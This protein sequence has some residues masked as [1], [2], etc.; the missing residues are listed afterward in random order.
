MEK[1]DILKLIEDVTA[2]AA[3]ASPEVR[4]KLQGKLLDLKSLLESKK[5]TGNPDYLDEK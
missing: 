1:A 3:G 5:D 2:R 4:R